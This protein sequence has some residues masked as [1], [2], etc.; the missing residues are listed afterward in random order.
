M[1]SACCG[2]FLDILCVLISMQTRYSG[3]FSVLTV[4]CLLLGLLGRWI[5]SL[6]V[7]LQKPLI[8]SF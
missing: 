5:W 8:K 6:N 1:P 2:L 7:A 4:L 3:E